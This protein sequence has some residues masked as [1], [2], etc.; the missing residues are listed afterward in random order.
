MEGALPRCHSGWLSVNAANSASVTGI[1]RI[2]KE[3]TL[4]GALSALPPDSTLMND[5]E[6]IATYSAAD[7]GTEMSSTAAASRAHKADFDWPD[8]G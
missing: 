2:A 8:A 6:G 7:A 5:P 1:E 4:T 3:A